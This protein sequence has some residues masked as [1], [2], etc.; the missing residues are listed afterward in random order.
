MRRWSVFA[1][2]GILIVPTV[3]AAQD[4]KPAKEADQEDDRV[5]FRAD[6]GSFE[7]NVYYLRNNVVMSHKDAT[8][9]CD[10]GWVNNKEKTGEA[11]GHLR[12]VDPDNVIVGD[13]L[14]ADFDDGRATIIGNV[15]LTHEKGL[16]APPEEDSAAPTSQESPP[17]EPAA[18]DGGDAAPAPAAEEPSASAQ[19]GGEG[20]EGDEAEGGSEIDKAREKRTVITCDRLDFYYDENRAVASGNVVARQEDKTVYTKRAVY[21]EDAQVLHCDGPTRLT[22]KDGDDLTV[23]G[24]IVFYNE[25]RLVF[26]GLAGFTPRQRKKKETAEAASATGTSEES[27]ATTSP[28]PASPEAKSPAPEPPK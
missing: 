15:R 7:N 27:A 1:L 12:I 25:D 13:L 14:Q 4:Q 5:Q 26:E 23:A 20:A 11:R 8:F 3:C 2:V 19:Q 17:P 21:D 10:E 28:S 22:T 9:Y 18:S 16:N 6:Q 24:V